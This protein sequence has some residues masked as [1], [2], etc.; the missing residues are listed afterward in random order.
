MID[1]AHFELWSSKYWGWLG[2]FKSTLLLVETQNIL[3]IIFD[4]APS[5]IIN[6]AS[7]PPMPFLTMM[8]IS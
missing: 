4:F 5:E 7:P 8:R 2:V 1:H 6:P 3:K